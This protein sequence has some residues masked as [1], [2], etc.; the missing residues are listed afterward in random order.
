MKMH[1]S[2]LVPVEVGCEEENQAETEAIK[3]MIA[4][5]TKKMA[6]SEKNDIMSSIHRDRLFALQ[7]TFA[8]NVVRAVSDKMEPYFEQTED[9]EYLEFYEEEGLEEEYEK[10]TIDCI[11]TPDGRYVPAYQLS[12]MFTVRDGKVYQRKAGPCQHEMRT[13]KSKKYEAV[14]SCSYKKVYRTFEEFAT[15]SRGCVYDEEEQAYGYYFN[16]NGFYD[17]YVIGGRWPCVFLVKDTCEEYSFGESYRINETGGAPE[18]YLW[19]SAARKKDIEW[20]AM[21]SLAKKNARDNYE[22]LKKAYQEQKMPEGYYGR[23]TEEGIIGFCDMY[24]IKGECLEQYMHRRCLDGKHIY[25]PMFYGMLRPDGY[26][27]K[28]DMFHHQKTKKSD[29]DN[30]MCRKMDSF[31]NDLDDDT[32]LVGVD[33]HS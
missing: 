1:F 28:D 18:G 30:A 12:H 2:I 19:V 20:D 5:I 22:I 8:R 25:P 3:Q 29:V 15:E 24:Y 32:V 9:P 31:I 6:D 26:Y 33:I 13:R 7:S 10:G 21:M 14:P 27:S 23:F 17:W 4:L 11:K 16:P